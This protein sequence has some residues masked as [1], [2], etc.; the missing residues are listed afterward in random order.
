MHRVP[1][2][3]LVPEKAATGRHWSG[4]CGGGGAVCVVTGSKRSGILSPAGVNIHTGSGLT[5]PS[6]Q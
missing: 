1:P 5:Q 6:V 3:L 4:D 2:S